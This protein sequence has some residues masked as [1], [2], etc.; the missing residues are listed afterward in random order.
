[1]HVLSANPL[2]SMISAD[3]SGD[4]RYDRIKAVVA[5]RLGIGPA[6]LDDDSRIE[7]LGLDS[8]AFAEALVAVAEFYAVEVAADEIAA[9]VTP[10]MTLR[11]L[12]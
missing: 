9:R 3:R 10:V 12:I 4:M 7:Q 2:D 6:Y 11:D 5:S 1:M 8:V